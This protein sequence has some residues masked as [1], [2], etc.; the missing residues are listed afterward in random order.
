M[1]IICLV[2][3]DTIR[4]HK[5]KPSTFLLGSKIIINY[6]RLPIIK[7]EKHRD[8]LAPI[9]NKACYNG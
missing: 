6:E 8:N 3:K 2:P 7:K 4:V 5:L 1:Y 9:I